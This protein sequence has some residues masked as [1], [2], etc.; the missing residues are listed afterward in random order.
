MRGGR[1]E[2]I[3][4]RLLYNCVKL[5]HVH[6][7]CET[8]NMT[9][10]QAVRKSWLIS[11]LLPVES[12]QTERETDRQTKY[13]NPRC[14]CAPRVNEQVLGSCGNTSTCIENSWSKAEERRQEKIRAMYTYRRYWGEGNLFSSWCTGWVFCS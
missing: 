7:V 2:I 5:A 6:C 10:R 9:S 1:K 11:R 4:Q 3:A 8:C 12:D 14:A 13:C